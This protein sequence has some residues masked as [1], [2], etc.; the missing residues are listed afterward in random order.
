MF[1]SNWSILRISSI[2]PRSMNSIINNGNSMRGKHN[3]ERNYDLTLYSIVSRSVSIT[4][5]ITQLQSH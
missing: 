3:W 5:I 4:E 2:T 1:V